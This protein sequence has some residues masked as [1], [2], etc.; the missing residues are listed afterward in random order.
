MIRFDWDEEK[1]WS[2]FLKHGV[3]FSEA[4]FSWKDPFA[5]EVYD[6]HYP[7]SEHRYLNFGKHPKLGLLAVVFT[8]KSD[9][10]RII[11]ARRATKKEKEFYERRI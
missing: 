2:N 7:P 4:I 11:S 8:E 3:L 6:D 5:F 9:S 1:E 10:I